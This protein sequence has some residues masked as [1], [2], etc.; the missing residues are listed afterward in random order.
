[1]FLQTLLQ[2]MEYDVHTIEWSDSST[3]ISQAKRLGA[4]KTMKHVEL[5]YFHLQQLVAARR[6]YPRKVWGQEN[7]ADLMTKYVDEKTLTKLRPSLGLS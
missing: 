7:T 2:E 1:M 4:S 3:G 6:I 5:K